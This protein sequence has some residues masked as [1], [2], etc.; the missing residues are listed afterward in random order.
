VIDWKTH[1]NFFKISCAITLAIGQA[2]RLLDGPKSSPLWSC[3][4]IGLPIRNLSDIVCASAGRRRITFPNHQ[5]PITLP[6]T[7]HFSLLTA[8]LADLR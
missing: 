5:S 7:N 4:S 1:R 3:R 8:A 6:L 2:Y